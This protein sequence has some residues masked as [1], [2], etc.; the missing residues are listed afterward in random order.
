MDASHPTILAPIAIFLGCIPPHRSAATPAGNPATKNKHGAQNSLRHQHQLTTRG[1]QQQSGCKIPPLLPL[2][3][4]A[5]KW[6]LQPEDA[7]TN[8]AMIIHC[9]PSADEK[10]TYSNIQIQPYMSESTLREILNQARHPPQ[11]KNTHGAEATKETQRPMINASAQ[12][13][14]KPAKS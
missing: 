1:G 5:Q 7:A 10:Q 14:P 4:M 2:R 3:H 13:Q 6:T 11:L 9:E 8:R 12:Y